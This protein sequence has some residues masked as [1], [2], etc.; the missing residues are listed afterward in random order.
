MHGAPVII[1]T[2]A[3]L[4]RYPVKSMAG[5][6]CDSVT[7]GPR[8]VPGDRGWAVWDEQRQGITSAK[9]LP[10]LR[11]CAVRYLAEPTIG[12]GSPEVEVR[13][14]DGRVFRSGMPGTSAPLSDYLGRPVSLRPLG[15]L[16]SDT[17]PRLTMQG[18]PEEAVRAM[19]ALAPGEPMPDY[20]GFTPDRLRV[21]RQGNFF[22]AYPLHLLTHTSLQSL[23]ALAPGSR[24]DPRRFRMNLLIDSP[25]AGSSSVDGAAP[26]LDR[27]PEQAWVGRRLRIGSAVIDV[28][29]GCPRCAAVTQPVDELPQDREIMKTLVRETHHVAGVYA[30]V[31]VPGVARVGD[32]CALV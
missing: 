10:S 20:T 27:Y 3:G 21:L 2:V 24:W 16:G 9:R 29:I 14:P 5:E 26:S 13:L 1:G 12:E 15:P 28:A 7:L 19:H 23:A 17:P 30:T 25:S 32:V 4:W 6:A 22:D 8:G 18:E 11:A 31:V